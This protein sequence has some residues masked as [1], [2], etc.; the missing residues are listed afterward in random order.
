MSSVDFILVTSYIQVI[1]STQSVMHSPLHKF[2]ARAAAVLCIPFFVC[3]GIF[4]ADASQEWAAQ[5]SI[6][7]GFMI[8]GI[9][10]IGFLVD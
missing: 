5:L 7:F 9:L 4:F 2:I 6:V 1:L 10:T 3:M 8:V